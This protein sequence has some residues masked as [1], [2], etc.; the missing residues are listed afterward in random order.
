[1]MRNIF[2]ELTFNLLII[3]DTRF[4]MQYT[5]IMDK[6][7]QINEST[8]PT[9]FPPARYVSI[10]NFTNLLFP[11]LLVGASILLL[12]MLFMGAFKFITAGGN[13]ENIDSAKNLFTYAILGFVF[14]ILSFLIVKILGFVLG[15]DVF[16]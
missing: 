3:L 16:I 8:L 14:I 1:M 10:A 11:V 12:G 4:R 2:C 5:Q 13:P 9:F 6:L 15:V 7:A